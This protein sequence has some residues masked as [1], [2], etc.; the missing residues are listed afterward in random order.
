MPSGSSEIF[1]VLDINQVMNAVPFIKEKWEIIGFSLNIS[2][3]ILNGICQKASEQKIVEK[4]L[5]CC[6]KML[7]Y[8]FQ[9][10]DP[11]HITADAIMKA[12]SAPLVDLTEDKVSKSK[13]ALTSYIFNSSNFIEEYA[14]T[15]PK[16]HEKAYVE[17]KT[18]VCIEFKK[19]QCSI[20]NIFLY[21][22]IVNVDPKIYQNTSSFP[23]LFASFEKH[24]RMNKGDIGWL[25]AIAEYVNCTKALEIIENYESLS[26]VDKTT[27]NNCILNIAS[28]MFFA[29][30]SNKPLENC[31]IKDS[32]NAKAVTCKIVGVPEIDSTLEFSGVGSIIFY[33]RVEKTT[34]IVIPKTIDSS[35]L[36]SC[37]LADITHIG[38]ITDGNIQLRT[39]DEP[40]LQGN[41]CIAAL[42]L[43]LM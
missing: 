36:K 31:T 8:W 33:W 11:Q 35:L 26:I 37:K 2:K 34:E 20:D 29:K 25:K 22:Q 17:M 21:L 3:E 13:E 42:Q 43:I 40:K 16:D 23:D 30:I 15:P 24:K 12:I 19:S 27:W 39:I 1:P 10:S 6:I 14:I 41:L 18:N 32:S 4:S 7:S 5:F 9:N 38:I 28:K